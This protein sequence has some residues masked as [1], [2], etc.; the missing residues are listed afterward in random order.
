MSQKPRIETRAIHAG[1]TGN[2]AGAVAPPIHLSTTFER[3]PEGAL[4]G[5]YLYGR[6]GNPDRVALEAALADLEGGAECVTFASGLAALHS[7][8]LALEP[9]AR[10]LAPGDAYA[11]TTKMLAGPLAR[12]GLRTRPTDYLDADDLAAGL[13]EK[14]ALALL[15]TPSNPMLRITDLAAVAAACRRAGVLVAVD[16]TW[17]TP[18]LQR[19]LERGA[20]LVVH[21]TTKY[22][23]GHSDVTGGAVIVREGL[24]LTARLREIQIDTGPVPSPFD[25]WLLRRGLKTLPL[26]IRAQSATAAGVAAFLDAHPAVVEVFYP[27]LPNDP[28]FA[29]HA[30][31]AESGGAMLSF[32]VAGGEPAAKRAVARVRLATRATSLGGVE[33]LIE[34]RAASEP[35]GSPTPR[36]LLRMSVGLE[37][38]DDLIADLDHA[39]ATPAGGS[40]A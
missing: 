30:R 2:E 1:A 21:A 6:Y 12:W 32:R 38:Q 33:T 18:V 23:G 20:D 15:E 3:S 31:Q 7:I 13:A 17:L 25:A 39:L 9:G 35:A 8:F 37:H 40:D 19:P 36:D 16:N 26:R 5:G 14:P 28:G 11:G 24:D 27:G 34:H 10:V 4:P 22:I 29:T